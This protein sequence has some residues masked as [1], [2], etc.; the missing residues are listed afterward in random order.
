MA[1]RPL[2]R[3][4]KTPRVKKNTPKPERPIPISICKLKII[5]FAIDNHFK[6]KTKITL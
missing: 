1:S 3:N 2:S 6:K 4:K 5:L